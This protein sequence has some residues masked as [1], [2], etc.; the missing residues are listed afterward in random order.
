MRAVQLGERE[1]S[2]WERAS[3]WLQVHLLRD[4]PTDVFTLWVSIQQYVYTL[5]A[6]VFLKENNVLKYTNCLMILLVSYVHCSSKKTKL[7]GQEKN[8][9]DILK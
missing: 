6:S 9:T 3:R 8:H 7:P 4:A 2:S 1:E 5:D